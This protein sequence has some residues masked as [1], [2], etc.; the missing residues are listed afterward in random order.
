MRNRPSALAAAAA[1]AALLGVAGC[2][3]GSSAS[4]TSASGTGASGTGAS[5]TGTSGTGTPGTGTPGT[6]ASPRGRPEPT[7]TT[8]QLTI[9]L[10]RKDAAVMGE[11]GGYLRFANSGPAACQIGGWPAVTAVTAAGK[12]IRAA[13]AWHGTMLGDWRYTPPL[14]VLRLAPGAAAYAVLAA[15]DHSASTTRPCPAVRWLRVSPPAGS[16]HVT[17]SARLYGHVYLPACTS[18]RGTTAIQFSAVL[19]LTDLP[20]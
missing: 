2:A 20:H 3:A 11:E 4:G 13:R 12:T 16:G 18:F 1:V 7:C 19:P 8:S 17:L 6:G 5:G 9:T 14:P 15:G 10:T